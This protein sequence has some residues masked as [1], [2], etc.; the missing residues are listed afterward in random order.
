MPIGE[1]HAVH[2]AGTTCHGADQPIAP[3]FGPDGWRLISAKTRLL[4]RHQDSG[5][6]CN[7]GQRCWYANE[8]CL[9][10]LLTGAT[11]YV[12]GRLLRRL[13]QDGLAV[14]CL[15][16]NP[17][18]L[19]GRVSPRTELVR[20]DLL[21][22]S[23][24][25]AAF[26]GVDTAFYLVH[27]LQAGPEF[28]AREREAA[29][30]F[31][32]AARE[33]GVQRILYLGGLAHDGELSPHMR[34]RAETGNILRASGI[35]V[36]EFQASIVIGSGSA[37]FEMVRALVE[38]LPVMI[39]PRWVNTAAQPIAIE[40]VIEYLAAATRLPFKENLTVEIGGADVTSYAGIMREFARQRKLRRWIVRVPF[41]SPSLSSR[42]L[43][44]ITPVYASIGR[45]LIESVRH[46][47]VVLN[48]N[49]KELFSIRPMGITQAIERALANEDLPAA[50]SRWYDAR[51]RSGVESAAPEPGRDVLT[52][53]QT[54]RV[55]LPAD[56]AFA[57]IRRIGG[58]TGWYFG[59]LLWRIRGR[60]DLMLGGV[61]MRRGRPNP[62]TPLPGHALDFWRVELYEPGRRLRLFAEMKL[63]GRAW[64]EFRAEPDGNSTVLRQIA[65]FEPRGLN[66]LLYWYLLW[67]VH[68][69][70]FRGMLR[71]IAAAAM[72]AKP[73]LK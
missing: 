42:W 65:L 44:L 27:S 56:R 23:S 48:P 39:T 28:E 32:R 63:P 47:S 16:R 20:G 70:M 21:Q 17:E 41:L 45:Y 25:A 58:R 6:W 13:E 30:N 5:R 55:P 49:A 52:N 54:I 59:N 40:D 69:V 50:E 60:I 64:L 31:G 4:Y 14:R 61:G 36:L 68:E 15:C 3:Q 35:P 8:A 19:R 43:T 11:G 12:G 66:G 26:S 9:M 38:R 33:A 22:P 24:L 73:A 7:G 57:P 71:R 51:G 62:E 10:V 29:T 53:E 2:A 34:S 18:T 37:S 72:E 1:V 67:P 46:P